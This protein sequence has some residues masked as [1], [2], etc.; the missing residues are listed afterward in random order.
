[1]SLIRRNTG[2]F[3][4]LW[5]DVVTPDWFGGV[6]QFNHTL[7]AVNIREGAK[8]FMLELAVPGQ[9]KEDFNVE[10]DNDIMTVSMESGEE[11]EQK[12]QGY[13][14]R[15]FR[16]TSF[17]RAFTLPDTVDQEDIKAAYEDGILRFTLP[18]RAEALPKPKRLIEVG[19]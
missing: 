11:K 16:Y 6:D 12:E 1:M 18:K 9:K 3:P 8:E 2:L 17:K 10:V 7:P 19:K 14:R 5:N 13:T 15:E 4:S